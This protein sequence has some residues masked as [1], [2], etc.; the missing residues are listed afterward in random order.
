MDKRSRIP[1]AALLLAL[2]VPA[3]GCRPGAGGD[4]S[5]IVGSGEDSGGAAGQ[6]SLVFGTP[7]TL[8][9]VTWNIEEFPKK[10]Q[11]TITAVAEILE[12]LDVDLFALQ[13]ISDV[14]AFEQMVD[15]LPG[16]ESYVDSEWYAGLA[17]L[18][19]TSAIEVGRNYEIYTTQEYWSAFPRS[20]Q[21][22][23]FRFGAHEYVVINNHFK[24]CGN[25]HLELE[26]AWDEETRRMEATNLLKTYIDTHFDQSRV[27]VLGDLNDSLTD[28][29]TNNVFSSLLDDSENYRFADMGIAQGAA[30]QWSYPSYPSHLD[31]ILISNELF[32]GFEHEDSEVLSL[33][34]DEV[35]FDGWRDY[36]RTVSDHRPVALRMVLAE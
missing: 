35:F 25:G 24:C 3:L 18:Y 2:L 6:G 12:A 9:V 19:R 8:D 17:Y 23:E 31:H 11:A 14:R 36:E 26:D 33:P 20:P 22:M 5:A 7:D 13:E 16:W 29:P 30:S 1:N 10:G 28:T 34:V 27:F 4:D 21:V 32:G 15:H